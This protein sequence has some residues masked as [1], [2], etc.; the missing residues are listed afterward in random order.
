MR[1]FLTAATALAMTAASASA[2]AFD[3]NGYFFA[4]G[5]LGQSHYQI[6]NSL[7]GQPGVQS[8]L[9]KHDPAAALRIGYRWH[10]A[11]DYGVE[12]GYGYLGTAKLRSESSDGAAQANQKS[13]GWL[14][15]GNLQYNLAEHWY[16]SGRGGWYRSRNVF[17]SRSET[18]AGAI[19]SPQESVT[20]TG[21]YLGIG[22]GYNVNTHF[23]V[24]LHYDTFH[25]RGDGE[26]QKGVRVGLTSLGAEY[27]F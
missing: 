11:V 23:G 24:G 10:S 15:G 27:R 7:R 12:A 1:I 14:L 21:E 22:V 2:M 26:Y 4:N 16:V 18:P 5:N 25:S 9:D 13:R 17:Q 19:R 8:K 20:G 6:N 3:D